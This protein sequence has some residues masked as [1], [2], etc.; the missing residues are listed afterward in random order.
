MI[1][2]CTQETERCQAHSQDSVMITKTVTSYAALGN[3][4]ILLSVQIFLC[5][6]PFVLLYDNNNN[7]NDNVFLLACPLTNINSQL[8]TAIYCPPTLT[9]LSGL[10]IRDGDG[11]VPDSCYRIPRV[12]TSRALF[13]CSAAGMSQWLYHPQHSPLSSFSSTGSEENYREK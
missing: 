6:H 13:C 10:E 11:W 12:W 9:F 4:N 1:E 7:N 8:Y 5:A 2:D 3:G